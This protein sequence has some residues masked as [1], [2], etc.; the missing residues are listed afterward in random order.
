[1][2]LVWFWGNYLFVKFFF[3]LL[4]FAWR[5]EGEE[6]FRVF[7]I[8]EFKIDWEIYIILVIVIFNVGNVGKV[9]FVGERFGSL[10]VFFFKV[11]RFEIFF[12]IGGKE[13]I[14]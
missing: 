2:S 14:C 9:C 4:G 13:D 1:M 8:I 12:F 5:W 6:D 7:W 10:F 3:N 11:G